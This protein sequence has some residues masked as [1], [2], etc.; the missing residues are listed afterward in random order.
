MDLICR[1]E[2]RSDRDVMIERINDE[3]QEFAHIR[4]YKVR[5]FVEFR[6]KISQVCGNDFI[7]ISF[8]I[9]FIETFPSRL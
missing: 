6:R 5:F 2:Y 1:I 4:L 7:D 3:R 8:F 9:I